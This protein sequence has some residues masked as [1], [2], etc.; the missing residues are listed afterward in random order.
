MKT[1]STQLLM[2][3]GLAAIIITGYGFLSV[4][5][6]FVEIHDTIQL[7]QFDRTQMK[8]EHV[9]RLEKRPPNVEG[10]G[11]VA[12][13]QLVINLDNGP[14]NSSFRTQFMKRMVEF[15]DRNHLE[16]VLVYY[17]PYHSK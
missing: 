10:K 11:E 13:R 7:Q 5:D 15:A 14:N 17:P 12:I 9:A 16:I 2:I 4:P 1:L 3:V 8:Q 6:K